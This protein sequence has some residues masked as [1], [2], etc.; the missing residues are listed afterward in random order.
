MHPSCNLLRI[1]QCVHG[2]TAD[3]SQW[4]IARGAYPLTTYASYPTPSRSEQRTCGGDEGGEGGEGRGRWCGVRAVETVV[5]GEGGGEGS[6][7]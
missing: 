6:R 5:R 1:P 2:L 3:W 7:R 4:V